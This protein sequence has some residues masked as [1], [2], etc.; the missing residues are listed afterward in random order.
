MPQEWVS[1]SGTELST[2]R[3]SCYKVRL[4]HA[5]FLLYILLTRGR[6]SYHVTLFTL[7]CCSMKPM[8]DVAT[9]TWVSSASIRKKLFLSS[10]KY[11]GIET[12]KASFPILQGALVMTTSP[13]DGRNCWWHPHGTGFE[14]IKK[15][16]T[17]GIIEIEAKH[18]IAKLEPM[19]RN[20]TR[21]SWEVVNVKCKLQCRPLSIDEDA[22][23]LTHP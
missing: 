11:F 14:T 6:W 17:E 21:P 15:C 20:S 22:E 7:L 1:S 3:V 5:L 2:T 13:A 9:W 16:K 4:P 8:P 19:N 18:C 12:Q 23:T 10:L